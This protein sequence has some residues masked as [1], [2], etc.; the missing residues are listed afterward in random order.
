MRIISYNLNGIRSATNKGFIEWLKIE[1]ADIVCVQETQ[2]AK[3]NVDQSMF[4]DIGYD[5]Y[6]FSAQKKGYSGV[7]VFS[8]IKPTHVEYGTGHKVSDDEGRVI[9]LDFCDTWST[10]IFPLEPV[11]MKGKRSNTRGSTNSM[12]ISMA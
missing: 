4:N 7:A 5:D 10:L 3:D 9:Q 12:S 11:A 2:A 8:K 1:P 6:W